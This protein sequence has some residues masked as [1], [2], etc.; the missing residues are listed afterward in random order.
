M[1][2]RRLLI[3]DD[4]PE[5]GQTIQFIAEGAQ[6]ESIATDSP[7]AFF[8]QV[9]AWAPSHIALDLIMPRMDGVEVIAELARRGCRAQIIITSGVGSRVLDAAGRSAAAH[10]LNIVG[11]LSK[12]FSPSALRA[13]LHSGDTERSTPGPAAAPREA[14]EIN[15]GDLARAIHG[16]QL[17][18]AYQPK[19][20]CASG[21]LAGF[22]ALVRWKHPRHGLIMPDRFIPLAEERGMI[23]DLT[24]VVLAQSLGWFALFGPRAGVADCTLSVNLSAKSLRAPEFADRVAALCGDH[25]VDT[26]RVIFE[27]TETSAMEDPVASL[28]LLTR[29]RMKGFSLSI[30]DFGTGFSS[31]IQLVR[32]PF[33]EIKVDKSFVMNA[34]ESTESRTVVSS[35]IDLGQSLG[36]TVTAEGVEDAATLEFLKGEGCDLA[37]GYHIARPLWAEDVIPWVDRIPRIG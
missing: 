35:I 15:A 25:G 18:L 34:M 28:D 4:D 8:Q 27:I 19:I 12:P 22:E 20:A 26:R 31:M 3:L 33:S 24:E 6:F 17:V 7:E 10:G 37:Q 11:V 32:M 23:G 30:D 5:I 2:P 29:L 16:D 9:A 36:L 14:Y 13:L 1:N 21:A